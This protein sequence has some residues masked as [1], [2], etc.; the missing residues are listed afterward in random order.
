VNLAAKSVLYFIIFFL[1]LF[2]TCGL[3]A[4]A[5]F[6]ATGGIADPIFYAATAIS[7]GVILLVLYLVFERQD[8]EWW[9]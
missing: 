1:F 6:V 7:W 3:A 5:I 2:G 8:W 9:S 4:Y